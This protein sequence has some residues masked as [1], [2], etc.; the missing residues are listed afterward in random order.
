MKPQ[1][2]EVDT[3]LFY[4]PI[5][6]AVHPRVGDVAERSLAWITKFGLSADD[7]Q[8]KRLMATNSAEFYGRI[9][10]EGLEDRLQI[11]ADW[12]YW[13]FAFD[14]AWSYEGETTR[15]PD[16]LLALVGR[17]LRILQTLDARLCGNDPFLVALHD[18]AVRLSAG[19]TPVQMRQWVESH[20]LWLLGMAQRANFTARGIIP[21]LDAYLT[22]RLHDCGGAP[23]TAMI[24]IV[25]GVEVPCHEIDSPAVRALTEVAWM[26]A[27][28]D[29]ERVSHAKEVHGE[30]QVKNLVDVLMHERACSAQEA[31][32]TL[33][34][35]RDRMMCLFLRLREQTIPTASPILRRY[36]TDLGHMIA[37]N[38]EWSLGTARYTT[39]YGDAAVP[40]G[41]V[42]LSTG[43]VLE[44]ADDLCEPLPF[45]SIS[46][47]WEQLH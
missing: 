38:I 23:C 15:H 33:V 22:M 41:S 17:L 24:G 8:R 42:S 21:T 4:C 3:G 28:L 16:D 9:T 14:D 1:R 32:S 45:P 18:I 46:W 29:N 39:V 44:P 30:A 7:R 10:P 40:I 43:W 27:A 47:W 26:T 6:S 2:Y 34:V 19:S 5:Q 20:R 31:L 13:G 37:G 35:M 11:A 36:L 12:C 25:D